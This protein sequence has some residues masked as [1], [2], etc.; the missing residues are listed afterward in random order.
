M[1]KASTDQKR[2]KIRKKCEE[3][4]ILERVELY[5]VKGNKVLR[6]VNIRLHRNRAFDLR[7]EVK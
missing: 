1:T 2:S 7:E 4:N 3:A 5:I 6:I